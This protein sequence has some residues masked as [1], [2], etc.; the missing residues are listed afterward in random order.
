MRIIGGIYKR[1]R[2]DV[3]KSFNARPTTDFAKENLFNV[4]LHWIDLEDASALDLFAG[5]GSIS[6]EL[7][8]RG[9]KEVTSIEMRREHASFIRSVAQELDQ[10]ERMKVLQ[11]DVFRYLRHPSRT[12]AFDFIFADPPYKLKEIA[13]LPDLIINSGLLRDRGLIVVEHPKAYNFSNHPHFCEHREYGSVNFS[14][15]SLTSIS[16]ET[17]KNQD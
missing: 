8:S 3:P 11:T 9:C 7:V 12:D 6:A 13:E 17:L 14:F 1:R 10:E 15:F 5:T 4:L 2:F 16:D